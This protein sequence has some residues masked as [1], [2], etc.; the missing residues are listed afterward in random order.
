MYR[1]SIDENTDIYKQNLTD[2]TELASI[3]ID[4]NQPCIDSYVCTKYYPATRY[5]PPEWEISEAQLEYN[6]L[7][8]KMVDS[9]VDDIVDVLTELMNDATYNTKQ[10]WFD[11]LT[12]KLTDTKFDKI[13]LRWSERWEDDVHSI[14]QDAYDNSDK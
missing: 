6:D 9:L 12:S 11:E 8:D 7:P 14:L 3:I 5:D 4:D 13:V 2:L 1:V 10:V